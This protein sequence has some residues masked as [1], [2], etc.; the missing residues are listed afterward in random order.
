[1][2]HKDWPLDQKKKLMWP[3]ES[4]LTLF[5]KIRVRRGMAENDG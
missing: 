3:D 2:K 5:Q 1:M 4:K